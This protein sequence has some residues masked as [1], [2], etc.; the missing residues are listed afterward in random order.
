MVV[1]STNAEVADHAEVLEAGK[2]RTSDMINF[3]TEIISQVHLLTIRLTIHKFKYFLKLNSDEVLKLVMK[4]RF[5]DLKLVTKSHR[6][7]VPNIF[8]HNFLPNNPN[9]RSMLSATFSLTSLS[10][11]AI[12]NKC[13]TN[14]ILTSTNIQRLIV[15]IIRL[16]I[17]S[18]CETSFVFLGNSFKIQGRKVLLRKST[19][20]TVRRG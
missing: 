4:S 13:R 7:N 20:A 16:V 10:L 12:F 8:L 3:V 11:R 19:R 14:F 17:N 1:D 15:T 9:N 18:P 6:S 5:P 2:A